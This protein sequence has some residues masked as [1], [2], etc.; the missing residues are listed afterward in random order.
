MTLV[1]RFSLLFSSSAR[2][3][4]RQTPY[5]RVI[6]LWLWYDGTLL[7]VPWTALEYLTEPEAQHGGELTF[8]HL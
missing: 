7:L 2:S 8:T 6:K 4:Q 5:E 3:S 1:A